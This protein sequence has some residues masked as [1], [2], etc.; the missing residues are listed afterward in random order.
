MT[1]PGGASGMEV[2]GGRFSLLVRVM[3]GLPVG[4]A[5]VGVVERRRD[6]RAVRALERMRGGCMVVIGLEDGVGFGFGEKGVFD[7]SC[8]L[9]IASFSGGCGYRREIG[10]EERV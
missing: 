9:W 4:V 10:S 6:R 7:L 3:V 5:V 8:G 1:Q 2:A